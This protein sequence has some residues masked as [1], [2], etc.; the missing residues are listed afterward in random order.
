MSVRTL[1]RKLKE[2]GLKKR[3]NDGE[4]D[5]DMLRATIRGLMDEAGSLSGYRTIWHALRRRYH[6]HVSRER[7]T[8]IIKELDPLGV[9]ARNSATPAS[10]L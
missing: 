7:V 1:K 10:S 6:V 5:V 2:Y 9:E 8:G 3:G 4:I